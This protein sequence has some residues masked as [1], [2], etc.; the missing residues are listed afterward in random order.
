MKDVKIKDAK[1]FPKPN[2]IFKECKKWEEMTQGCMRVV[3]KK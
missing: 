1:F 2:A 3:E